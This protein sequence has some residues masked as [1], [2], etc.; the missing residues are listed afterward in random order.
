[1][2]GRPGLRNPAG[3]PPRAQALAYPKPDKECVMRVP[4]NSVVMVADGAKMLF[5]RNEGDGSYPNLQVVDAEQQSGAKS[6]DVATDRAG[7]ASST[8]T[9]SGSMG[10]ADPHQVAED[11]F[12]A[13]AADLLNRQAI[14]GA[15]EQLIIVAPAKTLGEMRK[16]YHGEL[17]KRLAGEL[18]KD[19]TGHPVDQIEKII[20]A[21]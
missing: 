7:Q 16:H 11:R 13:H 8:G 10:G 17:E 20:A 12:A 21:A 6:R 14:D 4:H 2:A 3:T 1:M 5:F 19:L 18:A 9:A 15:Y